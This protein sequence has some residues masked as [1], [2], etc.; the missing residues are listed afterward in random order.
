MAHFINPD[1]IFLSFVPLCMCLVIKLS[2][3]LSYFRNYHCADTI[4][5]SPRQSNRLAKSS[6]CHCTRLVY[7][8]LFWILHCHTF[9]I[10]W[11]SLLHKGIYTTV[12]ACKGIF[13]VYDEVMHAWSFL[14]FMVILGHFSVI[15]GHFASFRVILGHSGSF[16]VMLR[17][18]PKL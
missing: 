15:L 12:F 14:K 13:S 2:F 7:Y 1:N 8:M 17:S 11:S 18:M 4:N 16:W 3:F 10:C 5:H 9:A 6:L